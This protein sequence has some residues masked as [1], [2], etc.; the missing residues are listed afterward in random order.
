MSCVYKND[1]CLKSAEVETAIQLHRALKFVKMKS[2]EGR[3]LI[4]AVAAAKHG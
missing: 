2:L 1:D 3:K 4:L